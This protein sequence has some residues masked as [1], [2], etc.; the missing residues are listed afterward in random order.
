MNTFEQ[1]QN[2]L[3][4]KADLQARYNLLPYDGTSEVKEKYE[5]NTR[6]MNLSFIPIGISRLFLSE[7]SIYQ[8]IDIELFYLKSFKK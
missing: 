8:D 3:V 4:Q 6:K 2:L 1:I 5:L 7:K